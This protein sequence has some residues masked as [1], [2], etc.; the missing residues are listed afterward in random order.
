MKE[1]KCHIV[2]LAL[3]FKNSQVQLDDLSSALRKRMAIGDFNTMIMPEVQGM[4]EEIPRLQITSPIGYRLTSSKVRLDFFID[5]PLGVEAK[6]LEGFKE[7]CNKLLGVLA[8]FGC[9]YVRLGYVKTYFKSDEVPVQSFFEVAMKLPSEGLAEV[10]FNVTRKGNFDD[11]SY[12]DI[13]SFS[14]AYLN[15]RRGLVAI[16]DLN[17]DIGIGLKSVPDVQKI[18]DHFDVAS[19]AAS[20]EGFLEGR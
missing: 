2:Q 4:P 15:A 12:N 16:R 9:E 10:Q 5:L 19:S 3:F 13:F 17:T 6:D 18:I 14:T 7:N 20:I 8:D 1:Y 11:Y